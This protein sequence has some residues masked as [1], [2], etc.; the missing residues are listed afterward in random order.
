MDYAI[1]RMI[2]SNCFTQFPSCG[3]SRFAMFSGRYPFETGMI[4]NSLQMDPGNSGF[5]SL[6][7]KH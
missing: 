5:V 4:S 3:P 1:L 7:L 2:F 6:P